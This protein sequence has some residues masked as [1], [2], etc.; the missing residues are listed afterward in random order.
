LGNAIQGGGLTN[1]C[2]TTVNGV[3]PD[4]PDIITITAT[5]IGAVSSNILA[6]LSWT[7]AQA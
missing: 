6:R 4:G 1:T 2:P 7:E 5:N 3:Y